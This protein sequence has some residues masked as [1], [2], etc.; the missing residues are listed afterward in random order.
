V[1]VVVVQPLDVRSMRTQA[2]LGDNQL[3]MG[4]A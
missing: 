3:E 4:G 2:V 1:Q